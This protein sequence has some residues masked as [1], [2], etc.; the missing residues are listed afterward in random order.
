MEFNPDLRY[1]QQQFF[2]VT[3]KQ[4]R[5][6]LGGKE[7]N[8]YNNVNLSFI[9]TTPCNAACPFC[10]DRLKTIR[11]PREV[12]RERY[13]AKCDEVL[14]ALKPLNV[15]VSITGRE[16]S[17]DPDL[18][19]I[20]QILQSYGIRKTVVTTNGSGLMNAV[21]D[22]S[23][24][25]ILVDSGL[26]HLNLSRAHEDEIE[27]QQI[28]CFN[29]LQTNKALKQV[30]SRCPEKIRLSCVVLKDVRENLEQC[31]QYM[32]WALSIG[33]KNVVFRQ[34]MQ[35]DQ[36]APQHKRYYEQNLAPILPI[37]EQ[38]SHDSR[39]RFIRQVLG[40]YYYVEVWEYT[41][42]LGTVTV[43]FED[44]DLRK[45]AIYNDAHE[46]VIHELVLHRDG[47]LRKTWRE[48]SG[49]IL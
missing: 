36:D 32:D 43:C 17:I 33:V 41:G 18:P 21:A 47:I 39:F 38:V 35:F 12:S 40:Y 49:E 37:L 1:G 25:D 29:S 20:M 4:R 16:P 13:L 15:S 46:D 5:F 44:A 45:I 48:D 7:W 2:D 34:L 27:N 30:V 10:V 31:V 23:V 24:L 26:N 19:M 28:M 3:S 6:V 22:K 11:G 9:T 14:E 8:I 42:S